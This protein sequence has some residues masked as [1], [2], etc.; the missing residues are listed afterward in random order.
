MR[1]FKGKYLIKR[2]APGSKAPTLVSSDYQPLQSQEWHVAPKSNW[3]DR[4]RGLAANF[5]A[6][7][8]IHPAHVPQGL[9]T[10]YSAAWNPHPSYGH[11]LLSLRDLP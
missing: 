9:C 2:L 8:H 7:P 10:C 3:E 11:D 6:V 1:Q 5:H 4:K